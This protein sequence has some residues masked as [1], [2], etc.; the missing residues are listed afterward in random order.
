VRRELLHLVVAVVLLHALFIG[1]FFLFRLEH[2][3]STPRIAYAAAW[4][5]ATLVLVLR[6]L[7]RIRKRRGR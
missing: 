1:G 7:T 2:R 4:T 5:I 6:A 3:T